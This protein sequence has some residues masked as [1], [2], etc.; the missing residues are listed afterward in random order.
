MPT[1]ASSSGDVPSTSA[2]ANA[3]SAAAA[4]GLAPT[5]VEWPSSD[6][7]YLRNPRP[8]YPPQS[9]RLGEQ[10]KVIVRV[11]I[12]VDGSPQEAQVHQSSGH[13]RLDQAALATVLAWRYIPGKRAGAPEAMWFNVPINFV[14]E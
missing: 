1:A 14:L 7:D 5:R 4:P 9:R 3:P 2:N 13:D 6:A 10:G 12:G 8:D 11:L